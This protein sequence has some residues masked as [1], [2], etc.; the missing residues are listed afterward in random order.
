L[1]R[2][3]NRREEPDEYGPLYMAIERALWA[4]GPALVLFMLVGHFA[5][6]T[7][8]Q[9][10]AADLAMEIAAENVAFCSNWGIPAGSAEHTS[11]MLD[12]TG[13][14]ARAE[15]RVRDEIASQF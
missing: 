1:Y 3:N 2:E 7:A 12:L 14:R 15:Q 6:Q 4:L 9:Q 5:T 10:T 13:I 8:R 11:C